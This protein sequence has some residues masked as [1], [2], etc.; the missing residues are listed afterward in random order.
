MGKLGTLS[1]PMARLV[2]VKAIIKYLRTVPL[3]I[4]LIAIFVANPCPERS[5]VGL[6]ALAI[7]ATLI[8]SSS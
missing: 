1:L 2:A 5:L 8:A 4:P 6:A 3:R 7:S